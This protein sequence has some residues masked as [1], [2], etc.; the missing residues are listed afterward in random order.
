[1]RDLDEVN[2]RHARRA[3][4]WSHDD[5]GS[6]LLTV[7]LSPEDAELAKVPID[8]FTEAI[9]WDAGSAEPH[10]DHWGHGGHTKVTNLLLLCPFHH[11]LHHGGGYVVSLH[12]LARFAFHRPDGTLIAVAPLK[13]TGPDLRDRNRELGLTVDHKT[14]QPDWGGERLDLSHAVDTALGIGLAPRSQALGVEQQVRS[15]EAVDPLVIG[16]SRT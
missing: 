6:V 7:R 16:A 1:M 4:S 5:D 3:L 12:A 14:C 13:A 10:S 11:R 8:A 15:S 2:D 9:P